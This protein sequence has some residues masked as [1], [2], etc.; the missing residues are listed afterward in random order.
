M[1]V[2]LTL[3]G[4]FIVATIAASPAS[5]QKAGHYSGTTTDGSNIQFDVAYDSGSSTYSIT[6]ASIGFTAICRGPSGETL[7]TGWGFGLSQP[8]AS[9]KAI[10]TAVNDYYNFAIAVY[11]AGNNMHGNVTAR[12]PKLS[13]STTPPSQALFCLSPQKS[14][15]GS[16]QTAALA[17]TAKPAVIGSYMYDR[18]GRVVGV[19]APH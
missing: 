8:I 17:T 12:S 16:L 9:G 6:G 2:R 11:F 18:K 7:N 13:S 14:Y 19:V 4:A 3:A 1:T 10:F 15:T 5:A